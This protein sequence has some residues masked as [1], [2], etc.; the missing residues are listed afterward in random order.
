[1]SEAKRGLST[2][3]AGGRDY[4]PT[5]DDLA[6]L[7]DLP[8]RE[9]V[10]GGSTGVDQAG[11]EWAGNRGIPVKKFPADWKRYGRG[12]GP[13]RNREMAEYADAL[14]LLPGGRGTAAMRSEAVKAGIR[15][16]DFST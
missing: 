9:V 16:Y 13:R 2:I 7:N 10:S 5:E 15:I 11:E 14:V 1:M 12:A 3:I 4:Q 6:R 8:I